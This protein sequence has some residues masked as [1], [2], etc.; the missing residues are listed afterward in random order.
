MD[1]QDLIE[2]ICFLN[3]EIVEYYDDH[4]INDILKAAEETSKTFQHIAVTKCGATVESCRLIFN[5]AEIIECPYLVS[6]IESVFNHIRNLN[7]VEFSFC[8]NNIGHEFAVVKNNDEY[9]IIQSFIISY[10]PTVTVVDSKKLIQ[11]LVDLID[12]SKGSREDMMYWI[13]IDIG[14]LEVTSSELFVRI[15]TQVITI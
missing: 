12:I 10:G 15:P 11:F 6:D 7:Y 2:W 4:L 1:Y 13:G 14:D 8:F 5:V 9:L 3:L